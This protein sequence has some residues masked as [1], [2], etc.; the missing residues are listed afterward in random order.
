MK[1]SIEGN[2][3]SS[4]DDIKKYVA[5]HSDRLLEE[6]QLNYFGPIAGGI[7]LGLLLFIIFGPH[8]LPVAFVYAVI[9]SF[10][11]LFIA[12]ANTIRIRTWAEAYKDAKKDKKAGLQKL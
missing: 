3:F 8:N 9:T 5:K 12:N 2:V 1:V 11:A 6:Y 10:V 4:I 7:I